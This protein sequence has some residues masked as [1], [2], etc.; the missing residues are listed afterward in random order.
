MGRLESLNA[1]PTSTICSAMCV[2]SGSAADGIGGLEVLEGNMI[3][4]RVTS[5]VGKAAE[6]AM[7]ELEEGEEGEEN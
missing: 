6:V 2:F 7:D 3:A 1:S 4:E 5:L